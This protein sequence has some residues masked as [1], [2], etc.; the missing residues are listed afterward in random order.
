MPNIDLPSGRIHY[1]EQGRGVPLVLLHA[2]PGDSLDYASV[3]TPLA[4]YYRV[5]AP[6]WP[7]Y[8]SSGIPAQPE[9]ISALTY[10]RVLREFVDALGIAPALLVG[11][12]VGG[13]AAARL[14]AEVPKAVRGLVLVSPGG[15]TPHNFVTRTFCRLQGGRF[16]I[17][18]EHFAAWY[19]KH[20]SPTARAMLVRAAGE[21]SDPRRLA[22][23]RAVWR[24]FADPDHDLRVRARAIKAPT[25]L[26]FGQYDPVIPAKKDGRAAAES[27]R[28]A[29]LVVLPTGHA[30]FAESP[31]TFVDEVVPFLARCVAQ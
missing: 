2:N 15:F 23:N 14:A 20:R 8:G 12:S 28:D 1:R 18:P 19:I 9:S 13:N 5:I 7:G 4:R 25:L 24:S 22:V 10:Y 6:D 17:P 3:M 21:Q 16:S 29:R 30:P 11:N 27:I 26:L 31:A